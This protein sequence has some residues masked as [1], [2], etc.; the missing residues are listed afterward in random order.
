VGRNKFEPLRNEHRDE[1]EQEDRRT[2]NVPHK[3][4]DVAKSKQKGG[5]K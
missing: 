2:E 5:M 3:K 4:E 1:W